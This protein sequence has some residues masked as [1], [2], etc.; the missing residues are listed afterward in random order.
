MQLEEVESWF[1]KKTDELNQRAEQLIDGLQYVNVLPQRSETCEHLVI[2][3]DL[4]SPSAAR[5]PYQSWPD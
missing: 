2:K 3:K 4:G 5:G 1:K